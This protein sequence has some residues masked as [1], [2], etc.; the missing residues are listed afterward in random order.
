MKRALT[1]ILVIVM[2]CSFAACGEKGNPIV[3]YMEKNG[4]DLLETMEDSFA[5]SSGMTCTS[6]WE[7]KGNGLIVNI[8]I[9]ELEDLDDEVKNLMQEAYDSMG[10]YFDG[11]LK[12]MQKDIPE[13]E[14]FTLNV[15]EK[16]GDLI[17][18]IKMN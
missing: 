15:C 2:V 9:N 6:D 4:D 5:T 12:M 8:N 13:L 1:L 3:A 7:V 10:S 11:T 17:A 18:T 14:Y 16:D